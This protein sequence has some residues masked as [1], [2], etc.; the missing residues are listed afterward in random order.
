MFGN[1][2]QITKLSQQFVIS[3]FI[4]H[5]V[6]WSHVYIYCI[7]ENKWYE[8]KYLG[9]YEYNYFELIRV[10]LLN[11]G[12]RFTKTCNVIIIMPKHKRF[13]FFKRIWAPFYFIFQV[14]FIFT[15]IEEWK[16][17]W[18]TKVSLKFHYYCY[19]YYYYYYYYNIDKKYLMTMTF[20]HSSNYPFYHTY[21]WSNG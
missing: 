14:I 12:Y 11:F 8:R 7:L 20:C 1:N 19:Y 3:L 2:Q 18:R 9:K 21:L 4:L 16:C 5:I 6:W 17:F 10:L 13:I 15:L